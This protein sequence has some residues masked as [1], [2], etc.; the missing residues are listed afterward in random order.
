MKN[1]TN[2]ILVLLLTFVANTVIAKNVAINETVI[3]LSG[4]ESRFISYKGQNSIHLKNASA[5]I[6]DSNFTTGTIEYDVAFAQERG[7]LGVEFRKQDNNSEEFY[8]RPHQ[9]GNP[10]ATQYTPVYNGLSAWQLYHK[11]FSG[12]VNYRFNDWNHVKIVVAEN[13]GVVYVNDMEKPVFTIEEFLHSNQE[14]KI[15]FYSNLA[16]VYLSNI[17]VSNRV[18]D[19]LIQQQL[20][21][22]KSV[23]NFIH[24]W[25][26]SNGFNHQEL[27]NSSTLAY[28][29]T[30]D[31]TWTSLES[32]NYGIANLAKIQQITKEKDTVLAKTIITAKRNGSQKL[33]FGYSD[34]VKVFLNGQLIYTGDNSFKS[35][36][37]RYLGTIGLFDHLTLPLKRGNNELVFAVSERFGGWGVMAKLTDS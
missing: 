37:Y 4:E 19:N 31:L 17:K 20:N 5:S 26:V 1:L 36:D 22:E 28:K 33:S 30:R 35:R 32:D 10:D 27:N 18:E 14:G 8:I 24:K 34:K 16:D 11:G 3:K 13:Q 21:P 2:S 15:S 7:F 6:I 23:D 25:Q 12:K 29:W 9:S